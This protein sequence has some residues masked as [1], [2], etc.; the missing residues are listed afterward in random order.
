M[1]HFLSIAFELCQFVYFLKSCLCM[2]LDLRFGPTFCVY[3][4]K[5]WNPCYTLRKHKLKRAKTQAIH[6]VS[7][8]QSRVSVLLMDTNLIEAHRF[9][10][11]FK[12]LAHTVHARLKVMWTTV[13]SKMVCS[14]VHCT[15]I[16]WRI[17]WSKRCAALNGSFHS[18]LL[19]SFL[20]T[21]MAKYLQGSSMRSPNRLQWIALTHQPQNHQNRAHT[22]QANPLF[23]TL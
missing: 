11:T 8:I 4:L 1:L 6:T 19:G 23:L 22:V 15:S 2:C 9:I 13:H 12:A 3:V 10:K 18:L 20:S 7:L 5:C 14:S 21:T 16:S 17:I